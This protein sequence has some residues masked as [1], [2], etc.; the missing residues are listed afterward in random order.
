M[1]ELAERIAAL[2]PQ[3]RELLAL[4]LKESEVAPTLA[5][6]ISRRPVAEHAPLSFSQQRLWFLDQLEPGNSVYNIAVPLKLT[7]RL[8]VDVLQRSFDEVV[9]RHEIL[10]TT[11]VT[12][13]DAA[14]QSIVPS[15]TIPLRVNDLTHLPESERWPEA[16][17]LADAEAQ[18][19]FHLATGPLLR[20]GLIRVAEEELVRQAEHLINEK[21]NDFQLRFTG[22]EKI[23]YLAMSALMNLVEVLK[24]ESTGGEES[25]LLMEKLSEADA[26]ISQALKKQ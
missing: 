3:Q 2:T 12:T 23:D 10:R 13:N 19:P 24:K 26:L 7:G 8:K 11:F 5:R 9:R 25:A 15:L 6:G 18:Q 17:R 14:V 16:L 22:Q 21:F 1:N 4:R 20:I